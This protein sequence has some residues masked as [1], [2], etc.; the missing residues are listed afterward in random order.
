MSLSL[1]LNL[2]LNHR[3]FTTRE[4]VYLNKKKKER[5]KP[6]SSLCNNLACPIAGHRRAI[7]MF[8]QQTGDTCGNTEKGKHQ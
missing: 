5:E 1:S 4:A 3:N 2:L 8:T 6:C 7:P